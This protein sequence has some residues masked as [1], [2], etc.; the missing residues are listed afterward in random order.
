MK[1]HLHAYCA[2]ASEYL[3]KGVIFNLNYMYKV[4][5]SFRRNYTTQEP[6]LHGRLVAM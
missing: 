5:F 4:E 6:C 1:R 2:F 3:D